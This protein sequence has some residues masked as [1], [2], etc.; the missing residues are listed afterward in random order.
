M[1]KEKIK[2]WIIGVLTVA[3]LFSW[4]GPYFSDLDVTGAFAKDY[5]EVEGV[6]EGSYF[7]GSENAPVEIVSFSDFQCHFCAKFSLETFL[8]IREEYIKTGKVKFIF[9][10]LPLGFHQM[11]EPA[12]LAAMCA[13][14]QGK[15]WEYHDQLFENQGRLNNQY[16]RTLAEEL[17]LDVVE[18]NSCLNSKE[19]LQQIRL[20]LQAARE[21]GISGTP[22]FLVNGEK[23][24]GAL[25]FSEFKE[26]IEGKLGE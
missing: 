11:A 21:S 2:N 15:F 17:G 5:G 13:G 16:F 4:L 23:L 6:V 24:V 18:F 25:S 14:K 8:Q 9:R 22:S 10:H 7:Q 26:V 12:A 19:D 3:L 1:K 20:D